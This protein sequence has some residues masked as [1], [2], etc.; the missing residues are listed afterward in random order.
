MTDHNSAFGPSGKRIVH[1]D[2]VAID[3]PIYYNRF[4]S[5]NPYGMVYALKRDITVVKQGEE[6]LPG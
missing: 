6:W 1:A 4:G 5:V 3:Q 2:V